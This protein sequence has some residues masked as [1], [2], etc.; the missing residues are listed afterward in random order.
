MLRDVFE[1]LEVD[2]PD[3][4]HVLSVGDPVIQ[5]EQERGGLAELDRGPQHLVETGRVLGQQQDCRTAV[6][7]GALHPPECRGEIAQRGGAFCQRHAHRFRSS[8]RQDDVVGV[9]ESRER[10]LEIGPLVAI[11]DPQAHALHALDG[12]RGRP[13]IG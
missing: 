9:V 7:G 3:P 5:R 12:D 2:I 11:G 10:D 1:L 4:R 13:D 6:D 8:Q